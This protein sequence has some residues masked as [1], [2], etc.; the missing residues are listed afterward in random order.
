MPKG[1]TYGNHVNPVNNSQGHFSRLGPSES[2]MAQFLYPFAFR[3]VVFWFDDFTQNVAANLADHYTLG[4]DACNTAFAKSAGS[5]GR[6]T[7]TTAATAANFVAILTAAD[8]L[9]D[10]NAG[11]EMR[12]QLDDVCDICWEQGFTDPLGDNT[13]GALNDIDTPSVTNCA[14]DI[15]VIGQQ[16]DATLT[17]AAFVTDGSTACMNTT[18]T[19]LGTYA[20]T[21][22]TYHT[23]RIQLATNAAA[24]FV[25][26]ACNVL[27][28][29]AQHGSVTACQI[30][31]GT[32]LTARLITGP[33]GACD[34]ISSTI[35]YWALW[36]DRR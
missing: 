29:S 12:W 2:A 19:D 15:A 6:I 28:Q 4:T 35:D 9:G 24:A 5:G 3:D 21:A 17:T 25:F 7:G 11:Q 1:N 14:T 32:A 13:L 31:G 36:Q 33:I 34:A 8:W 27:V 18:K 26:N 23:T 10:R 16:T 30:E 20:P 22:A